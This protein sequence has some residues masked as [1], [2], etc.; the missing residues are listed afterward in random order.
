MVANQ[1][2]FNFNGQGFNFTLLQTAYE[3]LTSAIFENRFP[4]YVLTM[5]S[6]FIVIL[7]TNR[8]YIRTLLKCFSY[9]FTFIFYF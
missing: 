5:F 6:Q 9:P 8:I 1:Q 7:T 3:S 4:P 2:Q